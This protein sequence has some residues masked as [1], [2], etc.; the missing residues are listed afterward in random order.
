[1]KTPLT[2]SSQ[3]DIADAFYLHPEANGSSFRSEAI[4][5]FFAE[6]NGG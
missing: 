5:H 6:T 1:M 4:R 2:F 3:I